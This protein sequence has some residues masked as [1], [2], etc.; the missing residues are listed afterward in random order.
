[1]FT[2]PKL[3]IS[4]L[5]LALAVGTITV[6]VTSGYLLQPT[7]K[8]VVVKQVGKGHYTIAECILDDVCGVTKVAHTPLEVQAIVWA[9][10]SGGPIKPDWSEGLPKVDK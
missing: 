1:M 6:G 10:L 9:F 8:Q 7:Y 5:V 3:V 2:E 4:G